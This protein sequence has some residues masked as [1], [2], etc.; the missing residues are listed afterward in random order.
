MVALRG[1]RQTDPQSLLAAKL[2][3][4]F[5]GSSPDGG[6]APGHYLKSVARTDRTLSPRFQNLKLFQADLSQSRESIRLDHP[7][8]VL[9]RLFR[10]TL[11][12]VEAG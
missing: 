12:L 7:A 2:G 9:E 4:C 10:V 6:G 3:G 8:V 11:F 1:A 5:E